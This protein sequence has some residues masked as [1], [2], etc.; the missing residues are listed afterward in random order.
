MSQ[1]SPRAA[2]SPTDEQLHV[3][4]LA[5]T[6]GSVAVDA[7]A[8]SGKT[9]TL[10]LVAGALAGRGQYVAFNKAIVTDSKDKFPRHVRC[11]TAHSLAFGAIGKRYA[12]RLRS[13]RVPP[14]QTARLL[15]CGSFRYKTT[16]G[17][18]RVLE[19]IDIAR[20][21][22]QTVDRFASSADHEL[23]AHHVPLPKL[24]DPKVEGQ[25]EALQECVLPYARAA[26][27]DI[28]SLDGTLRFDHNHYL[29]MWHLTNPVIPADF[30]MF[31]E[32]QDADPVMLDIVGSQQAQVLYC[33]D[34]YQS[35]YEWRG[36]INAMERVRVEHHAWLTQSFRFGP[37]IAHEANHVL[38]RL[39]AKKLI[40]AT[41]TIASKIGPVAR[42]DVV[43]CRTNGGVLA[44]VID[45]LHDGLRPAVVGGVTELIEFAEACQKL[46]RGERTS[47]ADLAAFLTWDE[48]MI[49]VES[50][51]AEAG[52]IAMM[53]KLVNE[54][55][56]AELIG[57]LK[58]CCDERNA[59]ITIST[60][61]RSKG[62]EWP[63][64]K[65]GSDFIPLAEMD[66]AELR[67]AYVTVTRA[68]DQL[69]LSAWQVAKKTKSKPRAGF[70]AS[71]ASQTM[72]QRLRRRQ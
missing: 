50:D 17:D 55:G 29:K 56:S 7:L 42:P 62:R 16:F 12:H 38:Q 39:E 31:D 63:K 71:P 25:T 51:R 13:A 66:E 11:S 60:A 2:F 37:A 58:R 22:T 64:V 15:G 69:D 68:R 45:A 57:V 19:P 4:E 54:H 30:I 41:D 70:A 5:R 43:L 6:G 8:G 27:A 3:V 1:P 18:R 52:Q 49:W 44:A 20:L 23:V 46:Q 67:L 48:V 72:M 21:T 32:A 14:W 33:G 59:D 53:V 28:T 61:H 24:F 35:I 34:R 10:A 65:V 26:W 40:A 36:A 47:H 9:S